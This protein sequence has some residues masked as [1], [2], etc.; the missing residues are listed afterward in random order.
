MTPIQDEMTYD[1]HSNISQYTGM[2]SSNAHT[3]QTDMYFQPLQIW[4]IRKENEY[5]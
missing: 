5:F 4:L 2:T 3:A 1:D